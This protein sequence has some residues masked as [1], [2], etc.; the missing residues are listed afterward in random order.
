VLRYHKNVASSLLLLSEAESNLFVQYNILIKYYYLYL[1]EK[2]YLKEKQDQ[3]YSKNLYTL[4]NNLCRFINLKKSE[5]T[6][7][8]LNF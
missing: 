3:F 4:Y 8:N 5:F 2:I 1:Y 6:V 7:K